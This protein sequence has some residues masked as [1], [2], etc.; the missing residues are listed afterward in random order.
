MASMPYI[1][2]HP[3]QLKDTSTSF[4]YQEVPRGEHHMR[5]YLLTD[6]SK[7]A[8]ARDIVKGRAGEEQLEEMADR[9]GEWDVHLGLV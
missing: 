4:T 6:V 9:Y 7:R 1:T 5:A 8:A 3:I 2:V